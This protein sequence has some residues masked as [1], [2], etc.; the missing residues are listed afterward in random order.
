MNLTHEQTGQ[1]A[2]NGALNPSLSE[3]DEKEEKHYMDGGKDE[4]GP[5]KAHVVG[6]PESNENRSYGYSC[7]LY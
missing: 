5:R 4:E 1:E 7:L 3:S 6:T 2:D